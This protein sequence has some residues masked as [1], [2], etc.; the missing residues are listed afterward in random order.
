MISPGD[1]VYST[2]TGSTGKDYSVNKPAV[3]MIGVDFVS[4][5]PYANYKLV[6]TIQS[7]S[8]NTISVQNTS[9][10]QI[11]LVIDD[12]TAAINTMP[13][14]A[15]LVALNGGTTIG[16]RGDSWDSN[17]FKGRIQIY[18]PSTSA[19]VTIFAN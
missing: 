13:A 15:S 16:S 2:Q 1:S 10:Q 12:G 9:G 17:T 8:R 14:N 3:P 18:A 7:A 4:S 11:V 5:G 6:T 19:F